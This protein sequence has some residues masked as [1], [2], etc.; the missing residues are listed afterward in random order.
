MHP[1]EKTGQAG[2]RAFFLLA[3]LLLIPLLAV[4]L[5]SSVFYKREDAPASPVPSDS[6]TTAAGSVQ[7][8]V[9]PPQTGAGGDTT[10]TSPRETY[11][12][13]PAD[14]SAILPPTAKVIPPST[15]RSAAETANLWAQALLEGNG[16]QQYALLSAELREAAL[17]TYQ[18]LAFDTSD[19]NYSLQ[20]YRLLS[21]AGPKVEIAYT[22]LDRE[23]GSH[24]SRQTLLIYEQDGAYRIGSLDSPT[25]TPYLTNPS[26]R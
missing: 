24:E 11:G 8:T 4:I 3:A 12:T 6:T 16:S 9:P 21:V 17:Q 19:I 23:G 2:G 14:L 7:P 1:S 13:L 26:L 22:Y 18:K 10:G 5:I 20:D 15:L 25:M